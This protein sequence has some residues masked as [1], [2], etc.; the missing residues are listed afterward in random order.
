MPAAR[1]CRR[2]LL[3]RQ[4]DVL[5][6]RL[7][8]Q[9]AGQAAHHQH[10]TGRAQLA[11]FVQRAQVVVARGLPAGRVG[12]GEHAAAAVARQ[13]QSQIAQACVPWPASRR[14]PPGRAR[15]PLRGC[16]AAQA[17]RISSSGQVPGPRCLRTVAVLMDSQ[18]WSLRLESRAVASTCPHAARSQVPGLRSRPALSASRNSSARCCS[19][20]VLCCPPTMVK[21]SCR[22]LR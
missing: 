22:P 15:A 16:R 4:H 9:R 18:R 13:F 12:V 17:S 6:C 10:Q 2:H 8:A 19:E 3:A 14:R 1:R 21:W 5:V 7:P 20:R 11:G